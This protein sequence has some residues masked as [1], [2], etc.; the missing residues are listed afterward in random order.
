MEFISNT[1]QIIVFK[2][3]TDGVRYLLLKRSPNDDVYPNIWQV[4]TGTREE[5]ET[6]LE[7]LLRELNEETGIQEFLNI[8]NVPYVATYHSMKRN[9]I[10]FSPVFAVEISNTLPIK[11]SNEHTDFIWTDLDTATKMMHIPSY[12]TS[13]NIV[14]SYILNPDSSHLFLIKL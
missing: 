6:P 8:W 10:C 5:N 11:L 1:I 12:A 3:S 4:C 13:L 9:A 2:R 7:A 14:N